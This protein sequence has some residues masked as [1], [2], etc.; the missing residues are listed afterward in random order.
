MSKRLF[1]IYYDDDI[2]PGDKIMIYNYTT[3]K[4]DEFIAILDDI[5]RNYNIDLNDIIMRYFPHIIN[6][7][8]FTYK[9]TQ[10][11]GNVIWLLVENSNGDD[12]YLNLHETVDCFY[13]IQMREGCTP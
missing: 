1:Y 10:R 7:I 4:E 5:S 6:G 11:I 9:R 12:I 3:V 8:P 13:I 2:G